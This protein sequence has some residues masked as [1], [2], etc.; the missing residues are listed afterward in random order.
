MRRRTLI[1][2]GTAAAL[3]GAASNAMAQSH[4]GGGATPSPSLNING[5][6]LPVITGGRLRNY[7]FVTLRLHLGAHATPETLRHKE[8]FFRDALVKAGHRTPFVLADDWTRLDANALSA[9]LMRSAAAIAG[10]GAV[11][12]VEVVSQAPR[13][14]ISPPR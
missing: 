11:T 3:T 9:S 12:R 1:A 4:G 6:G 7:V 5:V 2:A 13:R 14:Q 10:R 8:A